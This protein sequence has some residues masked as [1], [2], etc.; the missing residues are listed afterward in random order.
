ML[1]DK[2]KVG[3]V[4]KYID[5]DARGYMFERIVLFDTIVEITDD[6]LIM[7][8]GAIIKESDAG[9]DGLSFASNQYKKLE[10]LKDAMEDKQPPRALNTTYGPH[11]KRP[12]KN[13]YDI[14]T[15]SPLTSP[16]RIN[17][18]RLAH[19]KAAVD[20][21][22]ERKRIR[23][24]QLARQAEVL[25]E[26]HELVAKNNIVREEFHRAEEELKDRLIRERVTSFTEHVD[27]D[28][29]IWISVNEW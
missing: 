12:F 15:I 25:K 14:R 19:H 21:I 4:L 26:Y 9:P 8:S 23:D 18:S 5:R 29:E 24:Q 2:Y 11:Y 6:R 10:K 20:Q 17:A 1:K 27:S 22:L 13:A 28:G 16:E 7:E 3:Q